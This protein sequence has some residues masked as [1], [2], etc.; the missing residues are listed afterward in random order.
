MGAFGRGYGGGVSVKGMARW[1]WPAIFLGSVVSAQAASL[2]SFINTQNCDQIIDKRYF[3]ICYDYRAKSARFVG[4]VLDGSKVNAGNIRKRPRFYPER[5]IPARYRTYPSDYTHNEFHADRGHLASDASFDWSKA[6]QRA[7]YSMANV[8]PQYF[9]INRKTWI[10][11]EKYER[12]VAYRLGRLTVLNGVEYGDYSHRLRKSGI[13][14]P[15][16]FWKAVWNDAKG[17]KRCFYYRNRPIT[18]REA[19]RDRL[20]DHLVDCKR[21]LDSAAK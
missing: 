8:I 11:A 14:V 3:K 2:G 19:K 16:A 9:R 4:Y 7:T 20:R 5:A 13:T 21:L 17:F 1:L 15:T 6:S 10:K 12:Q 18:A